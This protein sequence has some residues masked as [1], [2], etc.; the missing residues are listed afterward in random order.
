MDNYVVNYYVNDITSDYNSVLFTY[1]NYNKIVRY[2]Y[3]IDVLSAVSCGNG[4]IDWSGLE[5]EKFNY[6]EN[7]KVYYFLDEQKTPIKITNAKGKVVGKYSYDEY[8]VPSFST[9]VNQYIG[10]CNVIGYAGYQYDSETM[11]YFVQSRY[12]NPSIGSFVS[13][14]MF[15]G[16]LTEPLSLN[17]Y[18]YCY[19]N[20]TMYI[21]PSGYYTA[22]EGMIA[23][24]QLQIYF[25]AYYSLSTYNTYVEY[26]VY[27]VKRNISFWGFADMVLDTGLMLEVYEIKPFSDKSYGRGRRQLTGYVNA[28]NTYG[29]KTAV[30][31]MT[32]SS[33][34][35]KLRLPYP[36][37]TTRIITYYTDPLDPGM[38]YYNISTSKKKELSAALVTVPEKESSKSKNNSKEVCEGVTTVVG[39]AAALY[40]TYRII[41]LI[42]SC[43]PV[44][45]WTLPANI[46]AP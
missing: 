42:P 33:V 5:K 40:V 24:Q 21:D 39:T 46:A 28:M 45:W 36:P 25:K 14:D 11:L 13:K 7:N 19:G 32:F 41:R 15:H 43:T 1:G 4:L 37:D 9:Y 17:R 6:V 10:K 2:S 16:V 20:P 8:G 12:Y 35:H 3:G 44:T 38:I 31:G 27:G 26:P 22:Y 23:H 29:Y 30:R 34:V 18:V